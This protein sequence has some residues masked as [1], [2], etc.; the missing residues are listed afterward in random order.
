MSVIYR[1]MPRF[2]DI[3][4]R[5]SAGKA[6]SREASSTFCL[7]MGAFVSLFLLL[8]V[9]GGTQ[10]SYANN[11]DLTG[12][13]ASP[14]HIRT[15]AVESANLPVPV[16]VHE[17][18]GQVT[19]ADD[20]RPLPGVNVV[21]KATTT[22]TVTDSDGRYS[23][24]A[25]A[26]TD[27]LVFSFVG[28]LSRE[29]PIAGRSVVDVQLSLDDV[30]LD[31]VVVVG[32][33]A[34]SKQTLSGSVSSVR[35]EELEMAPVTNTSNTLV[36]RVPGL[37]AT[38]SSGE[39]GSDGSVI[40]IRG[41]HTLGDNEPLV[42]IDGVPDRA[43][44][45]Q[46]ISASDIESIS[47][48]KDASAAIYG[49]R[50]ANGVILLTTKR[51]QPGKPRFNLE[52]N[53]GYN[54]P[55]RIPQMADAATYLTMLNEISMYA[56]REPAYSD[57]T[58]QK[59]RE[60]ADPWLFPNTDWYAETLKPLSAQTMGNVS[61]SGGSEDVRYYLSLRGLTEDGFYRNSATRYNQ[62]NFRSNFDARI[63]NSIQ[64]R[65]DVAGSVEDRNYPTR[66]VG[67]I[68]RMVMRGKPHLPAYWPN[69]LPG[70]DIEYGDNPAV[71]STSATGSNQDQRN[72]VQTRLELNVDVPAVEGLSFRVNGA[73]DRSFR[74]N[75]NWQTPW[76][77]YTWDGATYDENGV[78]V[79][80][81]SQRGYSE[82]RL[83]QEYDRGQNI[84]ANL[85]GTYDRVWGNHA[86]T[87]LVGTEAETFR[88]SF[89][90]A[91]RRNYITDQIDQL[92]AG[93]QEG[94]DN[95]G[96]A[97]EGAR[98]NYFSRLDRKSVV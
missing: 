40:R 20:G 46:R 24:S 33:G 97:S 8:S 31:E 49:A 54:Q 53:Q 23:L 68:F 59:Y 29:V 19:S 79:V 84:M 72:Y 32:Y 38:N 28:F 60:A 58:I 17:V 36:G 69:G 27:T 15:E 9:A 81:G 66:S 52:V 47:V 57:E 90:N 82:P 56:E 4:S 71:V 11:A 55:T 18:S 39:P 44:G 14:V 73:F 2:M 62:V 10:A 80:Q 86:M 50:A 3:R 76:T 67:E 63:N 45:L 93:G 61:V 6:A 7:S 89:F 92:F 87:V 83:F 41:N 43:G 26:S 12:P 64:L 85:V 30:L 65:F 13:L 75:K 88:S 74:E 48:L 51:G 22:G 78:P 96:R 5:V 16:S 34:R 77:L 91:F 25:P 95:S 70:P 94:Q 21:V 37:V 98:L 42:V 1:V 35:G